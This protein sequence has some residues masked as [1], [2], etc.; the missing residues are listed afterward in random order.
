MISKVYRYFLASALLGICAVTSAQTLSGSYFLDGSFERHK[1]N[2]ALSPE[3]TY[4]SLP[5]LGQIEVGAQSNVGADQFLFNSVSDPGM[6][7]TFMSSEVSADQFLNSLPDN[8]TVGVDMSLDIFSLGFR[9]FG[10]F[11][12]FDISLKNSEHV[13]APKSLFE[14]MKAGLS[15]GVYNVTDFNVNST[16]YA[17]FALGHSRQIIKNLTVGAKVKFLSGLAYVDGNVDELHAE[18][19]PDQWRVRTNATIRGAVGGTQ[20]KYTTDS[21]GSIDGLVTDDLEFNGTSGFGVAFDL[22]AVYDMSDI[23]NGLTLSA[24]LTDLGSIAWKNVQHFETDK[25][26]EVV[27]DGF[28]NYSLTGDNA[29]VMEDTMDQLKDDFKEMIKVYDKGNESCSTGLG[30]TARLGAEY[31]MPFLNWL[32]AGELITFRMGDWNYFESRTSINAE[33]CKWFDLAANVGVSSYG[34]SFGWIINL[35]PTG[36]NFFIGSD[37]ARYTKDQSGLPIGE[38]NA[39]LVFGINIPVGKRI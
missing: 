35:H 37:G 32:S 38:F 24:S 9:A 21:D 27:F 16:T 7:T 17:E 28:D 14:F 15:N 36:F 20:I 23:I 39:N 2:P 4:F 12:Y 1:L 5:F 30:A 19:G 13:S 3:R 22:G 25:N 8:S 11:N 6:L 34:A 10:G 33:P 26:K 29:S 18:I 31:Q